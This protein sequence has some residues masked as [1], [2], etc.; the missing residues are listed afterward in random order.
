MK[1]L[2]ISFLCALSMNIQALPGDLD[3]SFNPNAND[4][5]RTIA[6]QGDGKIIVGGK[7][8]SLGGATRMGFARLNTTGTA[9]AGFQG[10]L[11]NDSN[12]VSRS[13]AVLS[14]GSILSGRAVRAAGLTRF[15][16]AKFTPNGVVDQTFIAPLAI[17]SDALL[18]QDDGKILVGSRFLT[19]SGQGYVNRLRTDGSVDGI[20]LNSGGPVLT[21]AWQADGKFLLAGGDQSNV[22]KV[23]RFSTS[24]VQDTSFSMTVSHSNFN[25]DPYVHCLAV[26][27]DGK[28]VVGGHFT[29][30]NGQTRHHLA[31]LN[32]NGTLD[33][34][35]TS[36]FTNIYQRVLC[37]A[38]LTDG[39]IA[40][41]GGFDN[42]A[43]AA[44]SGFVMLHADGSVDTAFGSTI[45]DGAG[46]GMAVQ[47]DGK[48]LLCGSGHYQFGSTRRNGMARI[49]GYPATQ[50]LVID[51]PSRIR[52][53][54]GGGSPEVVRTQ[55]ALSTD[56]GVQ[57]TSLGEGTRITGGWE[58]PG[59]TLPLTGRLRARA[60]VQNG[61]GNGSPGWME[62]VINFTRVPE[63][64]IYNGP[65]VT[66]PE[67]TSGQVQTLDFGTTRQ[68]T[69]VGRAITISNAGNADLRLSTISVPSGYSITGLPALPLSIAPGQ[70]RSF[71]LILDSAVAGTQAGT[72]NVSSDDA[73]ESNFSFPVTGLVITPEIVVRNGT[74]AQ[75][76]ELTD[77]QASPVD[78]GIARQT[79]PA[80]R[81][82]LIANSGTAPLVVSTASVPEGFTL[83]N[84]AALPAT[85]GMNQSLTLMIQ[86]DAA[87][88]GTF[89]GTALINSDDYDE[90][91]FDF[92]IAGTVVS[93]EIALHDGALAAPE[94][95][96][97]QLV[98]VDFERNI[99]GT[100][101]T[102][103]FTIVNTGSVELKVDTVTMP[104]GY[105]TAGV[106]ATP[107]LIGIN[108]SLTFQINLT[109]TTVGT[110][111]GS[112]VISTDDLDEAEF[113]FPITGEVFIPD[114]VATAPSDVTTLLNRQTG[115]R[116][117]TVR[118]ANDTTATVPA[119][120]L[121]IH[122]LPD[123]V[124]VNNASERREDG[125]W[126]VYVRQTMNP[127]STQDILLEYFSANRGPTEITPQLTTE[128]VLNPPDLS[129]PGG[130]FVIDRVLLQQG[131]AVLI[132]FPTTPGRQYQVQYSHDGAN[133][134]ASLPE[135]RAA[136][137]RTQ[138]LD[139]GLPRTDSHPSAHASRFYRVLETETESETA[140]STSLTR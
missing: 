68:G 131:G 4:E 80:I 69:S 112:V 32:S 19:V 21:M 122:G 91:E 71:Q 6:L 43:N 104:P 8:T 53:L 129:V 10:P 79:I 72:V 56:G 25:T 132:E 78:F 70:T 46:N 24:G 107:L 28:V 86:L 26:Q 81:S 83:L 90:A 125:S 135:I 63:V 89:S 1:R 67:L 61:A 85:L 30:V 55:F 100:P 137:N 87:T 93:P 31:R 40:V 29:T 23:A 126:V 12:E 57:W 110:H 35:F 64:A 2:T 18:I 47:A 94:L 60:P 77:G 7:F 75:A 106:P 14:D 109:T 130:G 41:G 114:P 49:A 98:P 62:T 58:K 39:R 22:T 16:F 108:Q 27:P 44:S 15:H 52:W 134:Q 101:G 66:S 136:A 36:P 123:G 54:R 138:W 140:G 33:T 45:A 124:E 59:L 96:D 102:R 48:I 42:P 50:S 139:R 119:Y 113:D 99:Q 121:I 84:A 95:F 105:V 37:C 128:V 73:D 38:V 3:A 103:S 115:L 118:I 65:A 82:L 11:Y 117:Q 127:H 5:V 116:E 17:D 34:A 9:D 120:N 20:A 51:S 133:W 97:G 88:L 92:P 111:A 13:C 76:P 74:D